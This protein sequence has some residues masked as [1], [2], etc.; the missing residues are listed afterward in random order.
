MHWQQ[1]QLQWH[2]V[3]LTDGS[4]QLLSDVNAIH[5]LTKSEALLQESAVIHAQASAGPLASA[6]T[7]AKNNPSSEPEPGYP[8]SEFELV[9]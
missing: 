8:D 9:L 1:L 6:G 5:A 4:G 3:Q 7:I 2:T